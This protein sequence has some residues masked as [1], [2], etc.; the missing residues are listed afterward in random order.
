M[1]LFEK[2]LIPIDGSQQAHEA[3]VKGVELAKIL[4]SKIEII[5]I[6]TFSDEY[7]PFIAKGNITTK[8][9]TPPQW[10]S[11][12]LENIKQT[13]QK[14]IDEAFEYAKKAAPDLNITIKLLTGRAAENIIREA[15]K[16]KFDLIV[17]GCRGLGGIKGLVLG[18][19]S[20]SVVNGSKIPVMIV[21]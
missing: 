7:T 1:N 4:G 18:S 3:L 13:H 19:V 5:H 2:I 21:K 10:I 11:E 6:T 14:M 8:E 15:D 16:G 20:H 12:Y 17:I 9:S